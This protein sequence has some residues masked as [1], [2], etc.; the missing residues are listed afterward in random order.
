[1]VTA[2]DHAL[3]GRLGESVTTLRHLFDAATPGFAGWTI[4]VEP[5]LTC[6]QGRPGYQSALTTLATRA[7]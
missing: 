1:M 4:P 3:S 7:V 6:L 2:I 5:L